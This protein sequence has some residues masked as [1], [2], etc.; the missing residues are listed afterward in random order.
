M[1]YLNF[2]DANVFECYVWMVLEFR[3]LLVDVVETFGDATIMLS[4]GSKSLIVIG[5]QSLNVDVGEASARV[6]RNS[7]AMQDYFTSAQQTLD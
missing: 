1:A 7:A 5:S 6:G 2:F 3:V 4:A